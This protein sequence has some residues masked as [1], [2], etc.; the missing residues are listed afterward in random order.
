MPVPGPVPV[1]LKAIEMVV[2]TAPL[3]ERSGVVER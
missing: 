1:L 2:A 3:L